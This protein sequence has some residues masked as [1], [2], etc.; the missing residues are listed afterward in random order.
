MI[1][2]SFRQVPKPVNA[3]IP[4]QGGVPRHGEFRVGD[5]RGEIAQEILIFLKANL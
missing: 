3:T 1:L 2:F 4:R 5:A